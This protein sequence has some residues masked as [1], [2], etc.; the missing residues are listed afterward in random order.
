MSDDYQPR[1]GRPVAPWHR[2]FAWRPVDTVDR[3]WRWGRIMWRRRIQK[4]HGLNGGAD[5][6]FQYAIT[7]PSSSQPERANDEH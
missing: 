6:W 3:G 5:F 4:L 7:L 1:F 2:W